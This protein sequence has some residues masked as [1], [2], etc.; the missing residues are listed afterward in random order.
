MLCYFDIDW[1]EEIVELKG[2]RDLEISMTVLAGDTALGTV[3][4]T[5][6]ETALSELVR[7][8]ALQNKIMAARD[9]LGPT[10]PDNIIFTIKPK[11]V[12]CV[13]KAIKFPIV[14]D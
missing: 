10:K 4:G 3:T 2:L 14:V 5:V 11:G 13:P 6:S 9:N 1:P 7:G 8:N 12:D